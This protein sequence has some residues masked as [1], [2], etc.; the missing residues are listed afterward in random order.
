MLSRVILEDVGSIR[1]PVNYV[2]RIRIV[3]LFSREGLLFKCHTLV[4]PLGWTR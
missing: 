2:T 3:G 4:M 1:F